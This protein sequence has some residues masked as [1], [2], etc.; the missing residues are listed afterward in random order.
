[1]G[2]TRMRQN[3]DFNSTPSRVAVVGAGLAGSDCAWVL[4]E[5]YGCDVT[6]Y[7]MK[8]K[9]PTPAQSEP[10]H[11]AELVCSNSLKSKSLLNPAGLLKQELEALGSLVLRAARESEVPAGES[12]AVD[13]ILFSGAITK[14]LRGHPRIS[15]VEEVVRD[16]ASLEEKG[17]DAIVLA[18]GPLTHDAL[19]ADIRRMTGE[20]AL[21]FYDAIAPI[22]DGD[23]VDMSIAFFANR[24]MRSKAFEARTG[25]TV[26]FDA[27]TAK[28]EIEDPEVA[29]EDA[30]PEGDYL[31]LPLSKEEY[32]RFV[33]DVVAGDKVPF[34][35]FEEPR[36]FNG[37][38][39]I[40]VLAESG[41]RTLSFGPMKARGLVDPRTGRQPYACVQLRR[42][43]LRTQAYNMVGFQTRLTWTAQKVILR[44]LPG[45]A[46]A[47]FH[48]FGS[49]HRNTYVV[50]PRLLAPDFSLRARPRVFLAGQ[51]MGVEGYLESAA[52][53][54]LVGHAVA[55]RLKGN[56]VPL[57]V[58]PADTSLGALARF[59]LFSEP[60]HFTPMNIH[61]GLFGDLT[62]SDTARFA[63][64]QASL[65]PKA[66]PN[67][68]LRK[69]GK[70][71]K[72]LKRLL[73]SRRAENDF[74][75]WLA[76]A[77][78]AGLAKFS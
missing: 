78:D 23:T 76:K 16:L 13:R 64:E 69:P 42:E 10:H 19:A 18:T 66:N 17:F 5:G 21:S 49:M 58:P 25:L 48:R 7:E 11:F 1:M 47:E 73:L 75:G 34:H 61:W 68:P 14:T 77:R 2:P 51:L 43:S 22:V 62:E 57:D 8:S 53:G 50:S 67:H 15:V 54:T 38:Q 27:Q 26:N 30:A 45:L 65:L 24:A 46:Q 55:H 70:M 32:F 31:N 3:A 35:T 28:P 37:C 63:G 52:M 41:P 29:P 40:E 71:D 33:E 36:Y 9:E 60:K 39:P 56:A 4:A 20:E 74:S 44:T 59:V 72:S 6:L 12:L